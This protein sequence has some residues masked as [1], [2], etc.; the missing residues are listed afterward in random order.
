MTSLALLPLKLRPHLGTGRQRAL[1]TSVLA[2]PERLLCKFREERPL[3]ALS[4]AEL[5]RAVVA[6][7]DT[8]RSLLAQLSLTFKLE[9]SSPLADCLMSAVKTWQSAHK[10]GQPHP[11]GSCSVAVSLALLNFLSDS[12]GNALSDD[13]D[14]LLAVKSVVQLPPAELCHVFAHASARKTAKGTHILL[15]VRP[16]LQSP[17]LMHL[18]SIAEAVR[19]LGGEQLAAKPPGALV[20]KARS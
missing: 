11:Q 14:A 7:D 20:R 1:T 17:L 9:P 3:T 6:H 4:A 18:S 16:H 10:R 8:L 15:D 5:T 13:R 19:S 2:L 12:Q